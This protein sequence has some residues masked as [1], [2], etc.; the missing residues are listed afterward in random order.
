MSYVILTNFFAV[1]LSI[2]K[3]GTITIALPQS[4]NEVTLEHM[5]VPAA[6]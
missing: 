2:C 5:S 6:R 1:E 4:D 3:M